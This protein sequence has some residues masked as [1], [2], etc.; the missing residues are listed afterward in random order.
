MNKNMVL[1]IVMIELKAGPDDNGRRL[2]RILRKALPDHSLSLIH[3]LLRQKKVKVNG[4][5][6]SQNDHII[7]GDVIQIKVPDELPRQLISGHPPRLS[8]QPQLLRASAMQPLSDTGC[9]S[10]CHFP[11]APTPLLPASLILWQGS[12]IIV[13]NKPPGLTS[14]GEN[15]LDTLVKAWFAGQQAGGS[16]RS[17]SFKP[18]PLHR[19]DKPTS[20]AIAFSESLEGAQLFSRLLRERKLAKTYLALVEGVIAEK[21]V[22]HDDLSR[23]SSRKKTLVKTGLGAKGAVTAVRGLASNGAYTLAE[24]RIET[25]RTHQIRAQAAAH[26]YPLAGD[27]KYGGSPIPAIAQF[28]HFFLHAWKMEIPAGEAPLNFP[29][30]LIAPLPEAFLLLISQYFTKNPVL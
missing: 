29:F 4:K 12:G 8:D 2:D 11:G 24:L 19:L 10:Q 21:T 23:D 13:F 7:S 5:P 28:P 1:Y 27:A 3:R 14:H 9:L 30:P 17:L 26:G 22:W 6:Y 16:G 15:S 20:G 18:G 25:G